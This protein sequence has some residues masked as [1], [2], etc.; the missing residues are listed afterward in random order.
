M[1]VNY[2]IL[3]FLLLFFSH[4]S[5][6]DWA[7]KRASI[8][9]TEV[10]VEVWHED[11]AKAASAVDSVMQEM[12]RVDHLMSTHKETSALAKIN[13]LA[14]AGPVK[15]G[16]ELFGLIDKSLKCSEKTHGAFD[17][18]YAS[19]GYLYDYRHASR[20]Q[21]SEVESALQ[22]VDYRLISL[23]AD[24]Q[25]VTFKR[26]GM[27]IDLGG[28][29]KGYAVDQSIKI[30]ARQGIRHARVTA[31]GDTRVLGSRLG[32]PWTVGVRHPRASK[33][34]V[35]VI[36]L[37]DEAISTSGDYERY[38]D[39][40]GIRYHHIINPE[41]GDSAREVRSVSIIGPKAVMTDALSTSVFVL[42]VESGLE[43]INSMDDYEAIIVDKSG[44]LHYS[45]GLEQFQSAN[46]PEGSHNNLIPSL[47]ASVN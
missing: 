21:Q 3:P 35:A 6:A 27:R 38:F 11:S 16:A 19:V 13:R 29:A 10:A 8:M 9:G 30:L 5:I 17:I 28:I 22:A 32:R 39:E 23:D 45:T 33:K 40:S 26:E 20:P 44:S 42:G 2:M 41:T 15:V 7:K 24:K 46:E 25:T 34:M 4:A 18:T 1:R 12:Q 31:G 47:L 14:S 37:M 36:P 43:L